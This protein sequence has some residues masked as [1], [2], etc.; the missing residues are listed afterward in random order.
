[1]FES[2]EYEELAGFDDEMADFNESLN[3]AG[4]SNAE[5]DSKG[6]TSNDSRIFQ[7]I[8]VCL[9]SVQGSKYQLL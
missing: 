4:A 8:L 3:V 6:E 7:G 9:G 5:T 1:M 2:E